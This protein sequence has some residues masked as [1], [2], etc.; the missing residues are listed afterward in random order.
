MVK[1]VTFWREYKI[2]PQKMKKTL[3]L[4]RFIKIS[5]VT[6]LYDPDWLD[7]FREV[8]R[9]F[10][11][12]FFLHRNTKVHPMPPLPPVAPVCQSIFR[13]FFFLQFLAQITCLLMAPLIDS[14]SEAEAAA[15]SLGASEQWQ[16]G[17]SKEG[18]GEEQAWGC[19]S[20]SSLPLFP[21][22]CVFFRHTTWSVIS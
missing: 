12:S 2:E 15:R 4:L 22:T 21:A 17:T 7:L 9:D 10:K 20:L 3:P 16:M 8:D 1:V 11:I 19:L 5:K 18:T 14:S 13:F 6:L